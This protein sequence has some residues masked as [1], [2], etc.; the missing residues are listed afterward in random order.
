MPSHAVQEHAHGRRPGRR[1]R[2]THRRQ[3]WHRHLGQSRVVEADHA[4][5]RG[6]A[7]TAGGE[8]VPHADGDLVHAIVN[9]LGEYL[10]DKVVLT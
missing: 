7:H 8:P 9:N 10:V 6:H 3:Q 1:R 4:H 5:V 2:H